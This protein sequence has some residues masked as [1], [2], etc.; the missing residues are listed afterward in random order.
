MSALEELIRD[1]PPELQ[2]EVEDFARF[3]IVKQAGPPNAARQPKKLRLSWAGGLS[4]YRARFT[5]VK[6]QKESLNWWSD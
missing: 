1:M 5:S 4:E 3:L 6:L 2:Q